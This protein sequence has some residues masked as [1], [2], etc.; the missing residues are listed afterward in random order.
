MS[1]NNSSVL[2]A[3]AALLGALS[4]AACSHTVEGAGQDIQNAGSAV[5]QTARETND[6]NPSTP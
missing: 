6:G 4:L 2:V 3:V 1:R 5:E